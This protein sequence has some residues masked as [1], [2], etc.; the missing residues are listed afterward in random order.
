MF[1]ESIGSTTNSFIKQF[2][3]LFVLL[4]QT[5]YWALLGSFRKKPVSRKN[6]FAQTV[7]SGLDSL[8]IVFFVNFFI[9]IVLAMQSAYQLEQ[10]GATIYVAALVGVSMTREIG[11][12]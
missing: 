12:V 2:K 5:V 3:E 10:M 6:F 8:I 7:F 4:S 11:P 9:G 1:L